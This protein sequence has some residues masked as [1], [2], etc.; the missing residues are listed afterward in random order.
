MAAIDDLRADVAALQTNVDAVK[1]KIDALK[2]VPTG[3]AEADVQA[4]ADLVK[5]ANAAL[6]AA[7]A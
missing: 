6:V 5:A 7:V 2:A 3:V 4:Q 1:A